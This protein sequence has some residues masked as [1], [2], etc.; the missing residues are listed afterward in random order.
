MKFGTYH[1]DS[2]TGLD[3]A[4]QRFYASTYGR[5]NTADPFKRSAKLKDSQ[6]WN[7]YAYTRGDPVNRIDRRG[8]DDCDP[9]YGCD[10]DDDCDPDYGCY[11]SDQ[12]GSSN[13]GRGQS[14]GGGPKAPSGATYT[15]FT[16]AEAALQNNPECAKLI[17][18]NS[19]QSATQLIADLNNASVT[20]GTD[21][22]NGKVGVTQ[23]LNPDGSPAVDP[24]GNLLYFPSYQWAYTTGGN[25]QLNA[26]YFPD[27]T[28][29]NINIGGTM[30]SLL[31]V[32]NNTLGS[33]LN[34]QQFGMLVFFHEL[35]HIVNGS[36]D[37][38]AFSNSIIS[39][40]I[41]Q[42]QYPSGL[43]L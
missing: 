10:D 38:N 39:K 12:S 20:T 23:V 15:G 4:E 24:D 30:Q 42:A 31:S 25:I 9:D 37:S 13:Q 17:A 29:L 26:N 41:N 35:T 27:P 1:R 19:G 2:F 5:F 6:S 28:Q 22:G 18:G 36:P 14:G 3:Y 16:Q 43:R 8:L 40:C 32:V 11:D 34:V 7:R 21:N 33:Q